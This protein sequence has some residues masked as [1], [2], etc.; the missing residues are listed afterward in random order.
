MNEAMEFA[1]FA[2][3]IGG[4][5]T[6]FLDLWAEFQR[7]VFGI[8]SLDYAMVGRWIGHIPSGRLVH[9]PI[10]QSPP[11]A[12]ERIIGWTA[13]YGIG[14]L[15]AGALLWICGIE[16]ARQ[17]TFAPAL[18]TGIVTVSAPFFILQPG[19]GAGIAASKTPKPNVARLRSLVAHTMFGFGLYLAAQ[20][21]ALLLS[22]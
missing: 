2:A 4:G 6:L 21:S 5:A 18:I 15:F 16:W 14:I 17:P 1:I 19:M 7:R 10:S 20:I 12:G 3:L 9:A 22:S 8:P 11:V 13:H